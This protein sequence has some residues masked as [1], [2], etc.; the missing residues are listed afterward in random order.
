MGK[1]ITHRRDTDQPTLDDANLCEIDVATLIKLKLLIAAASGAGKSWLLRRLLEQ[2]FGRAQQFVIDPEGEY[3]TL[4]EIFPYL[5]VGPDGDI[6]IDLGPDPKPGQLSRPAA[7]ARQLL[8]MNASVILDLSELGDRQGEYVARFVGEGLMEAPRSLWHPLVLA[9]DECHYFAPENGAGVSAATE[10]MKRFA[11]AGRKRGASLWAATQRVA[12]LHK[13]VVAHLANK[14]IGRLDLE[15]DIDRARKSLGMSSAKAYDVLPSLDDGCFFAVGRA[16]TH[17]DPET[18][19]A[20]HRVTLIKTG[21]VRTT[22]PEA[23]S[24]PIPPTP[25]PEKIKELIARFASVKHL[26]PVASDDT[27]A[28]P[29]SGTAP[30]SAINYQAAYERVCGERDKY[31]KA[32][33]GW[34][35]RADQLEREV[36]ELRLR[37]RGF[38]REA[39]MLLDRVAKAREM[40]TIAVDDHNPPA[41]VARAAAAPAIDPGEVELANAWADAARR[42]DG[43]VPAPTARPAPPSEPDDAAALPAMDKAFL[44]VC[45][46]TDGPVTFAY[47]RFLTGYAPSGKLGTAWKR[48]RDKGWVVPKDDGVVLTAEGHKVLGFGYE[49]YPTG[50]AHREA[51]LAKLPAM[52]RSIL[53]HVCQAYPSGITFEQFRIRSGYAPSGKLGTAKKAL[54]DDLYITEEAGVMKANPL[55]FDPG[56]VGVRKETSRGIRNRLLNEETSPL[57]TMQRALLSQVC[58]ASGAVTFT[59][60]RERAGYAPSGKLG[61]AWKALR[62][63]NYIKPQGDGFVPS[64][65]LS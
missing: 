59:E 24:G 43:T 17:F 39:G 33:A 63:A 26:D 18:A 62:D 21:R 54:R 23:G 60:A 37:E 40:L 34:R 36:K 25:T 38:E 58:L 44:I 1:H 11:T 32:A 20:H 19:D 13:T 52:E 56:E 65:E 49:L 22:H 12:E 3:H 51:L 4:R 9:V 29:A 55:L 28:L 14:L 61:T 50:R 47:A 46:Q 15:N 35:D 41:E 27:T 16:F 31:Q 8:E 57:D 7:L 64:P 42:G 48:I 30:V 53:D 2:T 10:A 5:L 6:P 45:A